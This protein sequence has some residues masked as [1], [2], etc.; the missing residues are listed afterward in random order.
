M[1]ADPTARRSVRRQAA[2]SRVLM[3]PPPDPEAAE[4]AARIV[5]KA[6]QALRDGR[7]ADYPA[8][9]RHSH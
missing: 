9:Q 4:R 3:A 6:E 5:A 2:V 8:R 1:R 7:L